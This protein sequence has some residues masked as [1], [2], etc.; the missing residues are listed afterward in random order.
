MNIRK[1]TLTDAEGIAKVHI[2]SWKTTYA[3]IIPKEYLNSLSYEKQAKKW[4]NIIS[5][6]IVF[7]AEDNKG[8]IVGF[9]SGGK[10]RSKKYKGFEGELY[11]IY[12]LKKYQRRGIGK[13][14]IKPVLDEIKK[15]GL[16]SMLVLVLEENNSRLFY[17]KL[18]GVKL[19]TVEVEIAGKQLKEIAYGWG[20]INTLL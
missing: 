11:V 16:N 9:S 1:A 19:D 17:E 13:S 2:D 8:K 7:V 4:T 12:I 5:Q 6:E 3:N 20:D 10:E 18:G 14:L 15:M